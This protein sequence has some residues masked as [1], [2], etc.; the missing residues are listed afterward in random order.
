MTTTFRSTPRIW[1]VVVAIVVGACDLYDE[2][3][4]GVDVAQHPIDGSAADAAS[5]AAADA[6]VESTEICN[7]VDDDCDGTIDEGGQAYCET[8][9]LHADTLCGDGI[10]LKFDCDEG[11]IN[12]D[13]EPSNGCEP[14]CSCKPCD[15]AGAEDAGE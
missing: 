7:G 5:D 8:Q 12:C 11:F 15:D 6:C 9:V 13:G 14:Y 2:R 10:C 4:I 3:L 1:L